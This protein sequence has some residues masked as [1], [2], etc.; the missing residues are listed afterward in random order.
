V[1][2][3]ILCMAQL[4]KRE[5][6]DVLGVTPSAVQRMMDRGELRPSNTLTATTGRVIMHTFR[7][8]DVERLAAR[9]A[10]A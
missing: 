10:A 8:S 7:R 9:R 6:A 1:I 3:T 5:A 2:G 4:T